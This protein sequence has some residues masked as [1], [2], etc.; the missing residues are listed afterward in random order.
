[1]ELNP[2]IKTT[3]TDVWQHALNVDCPPPPGL[4][5]LRLCLPVYCTFSWDFLPRSDMVCI[6]LPVTWAKS[7]WL[8]SVASTVC[9]ISITSFKVAP[10]LCSILACV[11]LFKTPWIILL[12]IIVSPTFL[13]SLKS[14][15]RHRSG[16]TLAQV[17]AWWHQAINLIYVDLVRFWVHSPARNF[18]QKCIT[19]MTAD[20]HH[21]DYKIT[22]QWN[23]HG[24]TYH[25]LYWKLSGWTILHQTSLWSASEMKEN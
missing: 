9:A 24:D 25:I 3:F 10:L 18:T 8:C 16:L 12:R 15:C 19:L 1:M 4:P 7:F 22:S 13:M 17:L 2:N 5:V 21:D 23:E 20:W 11:V 6:E 14:I